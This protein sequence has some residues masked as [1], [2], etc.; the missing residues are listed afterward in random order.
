VARETPSIL[1]MSEALIP[2][3]LSSLALAAAASSPLR[4]FRRGGCWPLPRR[5]L[6]CLGAFDH[7]VVLQLRERGHDREYCGPG[8]SLA[9]PPDRYQPGPRSRP[10]PA[11]PMTAGPA[12]AAVP[13]RAH[14][15]RRRS[16]VPPDRWGADCL[17]AVVLGR[18]LSGRGTAAGLLT[19]GIP[20]PSPRQ[21]AGHSRC[22]VL[23]RSFCSS[24]REPGMRGRAA[25]CPFRAQPERG[26][27]E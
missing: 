27:K 22:K 17:D 15:R 8:R 9:P 3:P 1:P 10:G 12:Q 25:G 13:A 7:R 5:A 20:S 21:Q 23:S 2:L 18:V 16:L 11:L 19:A 24:V 26:P 4:A 6:L 14:R